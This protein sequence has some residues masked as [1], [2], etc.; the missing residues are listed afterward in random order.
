MQ[1]FYFYAGVLDD[2]TGE[3]HSSYYPHMVR[4]ANTPREACQKVI[5]TF[6]QV[7]IWPN[8]VIGPTGRSVTLNPGSSH[9]MTLTIGKSL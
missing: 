5:D 8:A 7:G 2:K 4:E 3:A 9:L 6:L 1:A